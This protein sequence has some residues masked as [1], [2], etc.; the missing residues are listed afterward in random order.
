MLVVRRRWYA[1]AYMMSGLRGS[2]SKSVTPVFS[3]IVKAAFQVAPPSVVLYKPRSPPAENNGPCAAT[4]TTFE[5]RGSTQILPI[6]S[7]FGSPA[8]FHV[9]PASVL[10]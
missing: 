1:A 5:L 8:F 7:E 3:V 10:L 4:Q 2:T 9:L 6:C